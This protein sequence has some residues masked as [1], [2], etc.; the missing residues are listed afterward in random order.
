MEIFTILMSQI[1]SAHVMTKS[2]ILFEKCDSNT[3]GLLKITKVVYGYLAGVPKGTQTEQNSIDLV[4][5]VISACSFTRSFVYFLKRF[6]F[7]LKHP[8]GNQREASYCTYSRVRVEY[9]EMKNYIK[10]NLH[11]TKDYHQRKYYFA[12]V[13]YTL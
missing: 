12:V 6:S 1:R 9:L 5:E 7:T 11:K 13:S 3:L 10:Y 2:I 4:Q 8:P